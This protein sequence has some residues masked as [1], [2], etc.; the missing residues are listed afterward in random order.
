MT[1]SHSIVLPRLFLPRLQII[2]LK[3]FKAYH[4]ENAVCINGF[5]HRDLAP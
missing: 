4:D 2:L 5:A 3:S 1:R